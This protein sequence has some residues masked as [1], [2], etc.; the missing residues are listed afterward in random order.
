MALTI[1]LFLHGYQGTPDN[2]FFKDIQRQLDKE[3]VK[4]ISPN[5]PTPNKPVYSEWKNAITNILI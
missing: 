5:L 3:D 1:V 2:G 4:Y